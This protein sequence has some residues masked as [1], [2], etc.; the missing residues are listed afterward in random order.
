MVSSE[1]TGL[2]ELNKL[3]IKN[4]MIVTLILS[5]S[6]LTFH[7][8]EMAFA[9]ETKSDENVYIKII[10]K[11]NLGE[12]KF[13]LKVH[14]CSDKT[15]KDP[16]FL[17]STDLDKYIGILEYTLLKNNCVDF[18][19]QGIAKDCQSVDILFVEYNRN[20]G[21]TRVESLRL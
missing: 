12:D 6:L 13:L 9:E 10:S 11:M 2:K 3:K 4:I 14:T 1:K 7:N 8:F 21:D 5:S 15:I 20:F 18:Y 19:I 17:I 16:V